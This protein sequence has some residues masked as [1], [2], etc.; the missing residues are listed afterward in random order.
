MHKGVSR[1]KIN[2]RDHLEDLRIHG[3]LI[4]KSIST[5]QDY[6]MRGQGLD[7]SATGEG[8]VADCREHGTLNLMWV[9]YNVGNLTGWETI[10]LRR[11]KSVPWRDKHFREHNALPT[12][13]PVP[14]HPDSMSCWQDAQAQMQWVQFMDGG[15]LRLWPHSNLLNEILWQ[16]RVKMG[17]LSWMIL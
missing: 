3:R 14:S 16:Q 7:P 2:A 1:G 13:C 12:G 17:T 4:L 5:Q 11:S 9:P 8:Q 15:V 10:S 6:R